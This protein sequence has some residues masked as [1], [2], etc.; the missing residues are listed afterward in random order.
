[1][2]TRSISTL[3]VGLTILI[4]CESATDVGAP[5]RAMPES[6]RTQ[7]GGVVISTSGGGKAQLP[8]GFSLLNF[9]FSANLTADGSAT[10]QFRQF[11]ESADGTVDFH[12]EVTCVSV[13][14]VNHRAWI[15][16]VVTQNNS[17]DPAARTS[18]HEVGDEV[19]FRVVDNGE[20]QSPSDRTTVFGFEPGPGGIITSAE[21][22]AR[23]LWT[24]GDANTWAVVRGNIQVRA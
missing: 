5:Q 23:Q 1:M 15:G 3:L 16:G 22:C 18:R 10:G 14:A 12:G 17:T 9:S 24:A 2:R 20:G 8:A 11:Y 21:Y 13:D 6:A 19:W 7:L 4:G